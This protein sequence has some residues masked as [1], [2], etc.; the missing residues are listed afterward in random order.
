MEETLHHLGRKKPCKRNPVNQLTTDKLCSSGISDAIVTLERGQLPTG[1][2]PLVAGIV[3]LVGE[4]LTSVEAK[5]FAAHVLRLV[6]VTFHAQSRPEEVVFRRWNRMGAP[7]LPSWAGLGCQAARGVHLRGA[8]LGLCPLHPI[9]GSG[10]REKVQ[11]CGRQRCIWRPCARSVQC[12]VIWH[13]MVLA[14][15]Y[16]PYIVILVSHSNWYA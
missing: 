13:H 1:Y 7:F 5:K 12:H 2:N 9:A 4:P 11:R 15:R 14:R 8:K 3:H 6:L 10:P 16:W